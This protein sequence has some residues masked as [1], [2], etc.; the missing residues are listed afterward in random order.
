MA[1]QDEITHDEQVQLRFQELDALEEG[2]LNAL[3]NLE[4]YRQ[5]MVR[6]YDKLVK[7]HV[8]RKGELVPVLRRPIVVTHKTKGKFEPKWEGPYVIEQVSDKGAYQLVDS[9]GVR[10]MPPINGRFLKKI[11]FLKFCLFC[12][13]SD[14]RWGNFFLW[15]FGSM[16]HSP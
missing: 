11:F 5:N 10:P 8:F 4:L 3:Q 7:Q 2:R 12:C 14:F 13:I 1:I 6:A 16:M 9:Q 15:A